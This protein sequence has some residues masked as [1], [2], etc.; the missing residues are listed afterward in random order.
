MI[1]QEHSLS[2]KPFQI[3]GAM[4]AIAGGLVRIAF[5]VFWLVAVFLAVGCERQDTPPVTTTLSVREKGT[6][7][8]VDDFVLVTGFKRTAKT[9]KVPIGPSP[10]G[11][12]NTYRVALRGAD[13]GVELAQEA[14]TH[15]EAPAMKGVKVQFEVVNYWVLKD[16]YL[17]GTF[18]GQMVGGFVKTGLPLVVELVREE[19]GTPDTNIEVCTFAESFLTDRLPLVSDEAELLPR[20]LTIFRGQL[21]R[22]LA[23][24]PDDERALAALRSVEQA[25]QQLERSVRAEGQIPQ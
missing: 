17:P 4:C 6:N 10:I 12:Y 1:A 15:T 22:C 9:V 18:T 8:T 16:G 11:Y 7:A 25:L 13:S 20:V 5:G 14:I 21:Q 3:A 23:A 2:V 19:P 24:T